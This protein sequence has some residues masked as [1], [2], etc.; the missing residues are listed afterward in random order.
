MSGWLFRVICTALGILGGPLGAVFGF[1]LGYLLDM[2]AAE[3]LLHRAVRRYL[4]NCIPPRTGELAVP[5]AAGCVALCVIYRRH[6]TAAERNECS[7]TLSA[8]E[9]IRD[10]R[11][12]RGRRRLADRI[13]NSISFFS[14]QIDLR[15]ARACWS[16]MTEADRR[17]VFSV[18]SPLARGN[19]TTLGAA[20]NLLSLP[21]EVWQQ[22]V[23]PEVFA[24]LDPGDCEVLGV[25]TVADIYEI[26]RAYRRLAAQFHPDTMTELSEVQR[27]EAEAVFVRVHDAYER[28]C[29]QIGAPD[30]RGAD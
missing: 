27:H 5:M 2:I 7:R 24:S 1:V 13:V 4:L 8:Q 22:L 6:P 26:R 12:S 28:L 17:T 18:C 16:E 9:I 14:R 19:R 29:S 11:D 20:A 10:E 15:A 3:L 23:S 25:S 21:S 30:Q